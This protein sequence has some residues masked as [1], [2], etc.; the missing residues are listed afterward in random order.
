MILK[1]LGGLAPI[2]IQLLM[3][4][5]Q[6]VIWLHLDD[7]KEFYLMVLYSHFDNALFH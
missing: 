3:A 4:E 1:Q 7:L 2:L 6:I 5:E